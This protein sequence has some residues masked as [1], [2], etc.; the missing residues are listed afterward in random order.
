[1]KAR[2]SIAL[3]ALAIALAGCGTA[4]GERAVSGAGIGA[5]AGAAIGAVTGMGAGT[6]AAIGAAAGAATGGLTKKR[7]VDLGDPAW[8]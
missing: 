4:P 5:G 8:K 7:Q 6:G 2:Y 1:M 3:L